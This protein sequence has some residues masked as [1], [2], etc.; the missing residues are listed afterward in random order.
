MSWAGEA[1]ELGG[2]FIKVEMRS[3]RVRK[4]ARFTVGVSLSKGSWNIERSFVALFLV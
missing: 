3:G 4:D 1:L 2:P